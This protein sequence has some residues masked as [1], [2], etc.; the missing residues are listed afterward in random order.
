MRLF[1]QI[2][3]HRQVVNNMLTKLKSRVQQWLSKEAKLVHDLGFTPNILS[4]LG[5]I[6]S[7]FSMLFYYMWEYNVYFLFAAP[8][9]LVLSGFCDALDGVLARK[10]GESTIFGGL[11]DSTLDRYADVFVLCGIMLGGLCSFYWGI[12]ALAGSLIVSY[13]RARSEA[14]GIKME[15]VGLAE[16][17]DRIVILVV[18]SFLTFLWLESLEWGM[19]LLALISNFTVIQRVRFFYQ[20]TKN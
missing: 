9:F 20:A 12:T 17:A 6:F 2:F 19:I 14:A 10:Y 8:L 15:S 13:V 18:A 3:L 4:V 5:F 1:K 7:V 11:L 16:R